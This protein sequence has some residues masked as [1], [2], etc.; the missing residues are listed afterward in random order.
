MIIDAHVH[1]P[2]GDE[3]DSLQKQKNQLLKDMKENHV[4]KCIVISDS[5]IHSTIGSMEEC[6]ELFGEEKNISVVAGISPNIHFEEQWR[7]LQKYLMRK[8]VVGI[9]LF[10]GH[11]AIYLTDERLEIVYETAIQYDVPVLFHSGWENSQYSDVSKVMEIAS[12][13][14]RLKLV[15]CHCFYP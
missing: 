15:C 9:K 2:V 8:Q 4:D 12:K 1:L 14:P 7:R 11:E 5:E 10:T 6:V 3:R 13:Y